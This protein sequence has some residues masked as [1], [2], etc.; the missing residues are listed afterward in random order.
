MK[1]VAF[2][3][4]ALLLAGPVYAQQNQ[5]G[6]VKRP[7]QAQ[8]GGG[9]VRADTTTKAFTMSTTGG[10]SIY[11]E[12]RDRDQW[13]VLNGGSPIINDTLT[14]G[15]GINA[16]AGNGAPA[17]FTAESSLVISSGMYQRFALAVRVIPAAGDTAT[18]IRLA[19]QIRGHITSA[20]DTNSTFAWLPFQVEAAIAGID[21]LG[22]YGTQVAGDHVSQA[23]PGE[24]KLQFDPRNYT[25]TSGVGNVFAF[26]SG[27]WIQLITNSG[28]WF[29]APYMSVRIRCLTGA[30]KPRVIA[31]LVGRP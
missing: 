21:S 20:V 2:I 24:F 19:V 31:Y 30:A 28:E 25:G 26:P 1:R 10:L 14:V 8:V 13:A 5:D 29:W 17:S 3:L 22:D 12:A 4:A 18:K 11:D 6:Q 16:G 7:F 27:R 15:S 9:V 23:G